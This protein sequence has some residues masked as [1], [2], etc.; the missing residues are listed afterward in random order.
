MR[1]SDSFLFL[2]WWWSWCNYVIFLLSPM[3][4]P[5][6][7]IAQKHGVNFKNAIFTFNRRLLLFLFHPMLRKLTK[8]EHLT[9]KAMATRS[10]TLAW[11]IPWGEEP[12]GLQSMG[13]RRVGH[14]WSDLA[15]AAAATICSYK[16]TLH[17]LFWTAICLFTEKYNIPQTLRGSCRKHFVNIWYLYN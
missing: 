6:S 1:K 8:V 2:S 9:E 4:P 11:K 13:S 10:S 15:A 16:I 7:L 14:D 3:L 12:G 5:H 17:L